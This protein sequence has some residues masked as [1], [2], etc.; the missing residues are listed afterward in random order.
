MNCALRVLGMPP[1]DLYPWTSIPPRSGCVRISRALRGYLLVY[2]AFLVIL[3]ASVGLA[4]YLQE[5]S[6]E[7]FRN[8]LGIA[9][10]IAGCT[11]LL[12]ALFL[13]GSN[14][15]LA[16][17]STRTLLVTAP[18]KPPF[19]MASDS[20][21]VFR[22]RREE[23]LARF[24]QSIVAGVTGLAVLGLAALVAVDVWLALGAYLAELAGF[25]YVLVRSRS[26]AQV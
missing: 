3:L 7:T 20:G 13:G 12:L 6:L 22:H 14:R 25:A 17:V 21:A 4:L 11:W 18:G 5:L 10:V 26:T 23:I 8:T 15:N 16:A 24:D 2:E 9:F 1:L 19:V